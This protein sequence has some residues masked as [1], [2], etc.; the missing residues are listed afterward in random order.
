LRRFFGSKNSEDETQI[1][2]DGVKEL[3][4]LVALLPAMF[5]GAPRCVTAL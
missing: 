2:V 5:L 4:K 3:S 1:S